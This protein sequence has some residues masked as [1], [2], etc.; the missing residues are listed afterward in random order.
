MSRIV[1]FG[2]ERLV[3][4]LSHTD[5]PVLNSL[6]QAG[7]DIVAVVA[8][9][10]GGRSRQNRE[11]E[12]ATVAA[13]YDIPVFLPNKPTEISEKLQELQAEI[14]VLVAYG[15]IVPQSVIDIFPRGIVNLHPSLLP[16]YRGSTPI[17]T[18]VLSGDATTGITLMNLT[19]EMDAGGIYAQE[20][21]ALTG[22]ENKFEVYDKLSKIGTKMLLDNLPQILDDKIQP[23]P[24]DTAEATY[25]QLLTKSDGNLDPKTMTAAECDRKIRAYLGWPKT[26]ID[27]RGRLIIVTKAKVRDEPNDST[28]E[29]AD[30][31]YLEII[32][33]IAPNSGRAMAAAD[34]VRGL[35]D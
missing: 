19:K 17:E 21:I 18:T 14:G 23:V 30:K 8:H 22:S 6:I 31:T 11:L 20:E 13:K 33:L 2:N 25:C 26:R 28:I 1:F 32:E 35:R 29:C 3:S 24:Q 34:Y 16:K 10:E 15:R 7:Y 9:H 27:F 4:G 5:T 12:V